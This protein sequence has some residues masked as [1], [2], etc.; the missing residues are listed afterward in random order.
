MAKLNSMMNKEG[1]HDLL[2]VPSMDIRN[3]KKREFNIFFKR[4]F[5]FILTSIFLAI[6]SPSL[7]FIALLIRL[8][9]KGPVAFIQKRSLSDDS[10]PFNMYKFRTMVAGANLEKK[11]LL[12]LNQ[13]NGA[14][15][16]IAN[17]PRV[18]KLGKFLREFSLDE[19]PQLINILKGEMSLVGPRP[20]PM[21]D[22]TMLDEEEKKNGWHRYR[23]KAMPGMT[24]LWVIGGRNNLGFEEM[25]LLD[26]YYIDHWSLWLDLKILL[27]T[28]PAILS[29]KGV[30]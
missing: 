9:S 16:K 22:Y 5:D 12:T 11:N 2:E 24:G 23:A 25:M 7:L 8:H 4:I 29:R 6:L 20:L 28:L 15:F 14:L 13:S 17:D 26:A 27:K 18:T 1:I 21:E 30:Y 3:S 10:K 19:L